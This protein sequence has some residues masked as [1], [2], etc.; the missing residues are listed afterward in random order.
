MSALSSLIKLFVSTI[1]IEGV[2]PIPLQG[3]GSDRKIYRFLHQNES[4]IGV[5]NPSVAENQAFLFLSKF[6][7]ERGIPTP[8]IYAQDLA[9]NCYLLEDL[10][11]MTLAQQVEQWN[12]QEQTEEIIT[13]YQKVIAWM[14]ELQIKS[15][16]QLDYHFCFQDNILDETTFRWDINYFRQYFFQ[17]F[18]PDDQESVTLTH[19]LETLIHQLNQYPKNSFV[20]RDF[21]AR[22]IMWKKDQPY[23]IDY[24]NGCPGALY[25]DFATLLYASKAGLSDPQRKELIQTYIQTFA[26][27]YSWGYEEF[28][29]A[30]YPFV[31]I[32][33]LRSL[34]TYGFLSTQKG[35]F[36][37]LAA[38]PRTIEEIFSLLHEYPSLQS[39]LALKELFAQWRENRNVM[40][41]ERLESRANQF[42]QTSS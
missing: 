35:K 2:V 24:Q 1:G 9:Q 4:W 41:Q 10:G 17:I 18:A 11:E 7:R 16:A 26:P 31:L 36:H 40:E 33:R 25:Y 12:Q 8:Q 39:W 5:T 6:F 32:R 38:I 29:N 42:K 20:Y 34:G 21:Q 15:H 30:L 14:P 3:D 13:A 37:F 19:E 22:N 27:W 23:F 28:C